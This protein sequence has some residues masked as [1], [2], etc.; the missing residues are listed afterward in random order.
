MAGS[1]AELIEEIGAENERK[2]GLTKRPPEARQ[3]DLRDIE[4]EI[5]RSAM[6]TVQDVLRFREIDP[7]EEGIPDEWVQ[8][9]GMLEAQRLH[10][11]ARVGWLPGKQAPCALKLA[12]NVMV[13]IV[14]ARSTEKAA[15]RA[16]NVV[17]VRMTAPPRSYPE[18]DVTP[19]EELEA[20]R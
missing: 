15:P 8:K 16:V 3:D 7:A 4:D 13:G 6:G 2:R 10:R 12:N 18:M 20:H 1:L 9:Y 14:K 17:L 19:K 11:L 5:L